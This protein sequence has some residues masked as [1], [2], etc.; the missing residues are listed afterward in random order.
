MFENFS[1]V[2]EGIVNVSDGVGRVRLGARSGLVIERAL[3][4]TI[5][6][7]SS[8][9]K[10]KEEEDD[11][12]ECMNVTIALQ[13]QVRDSSLELPETCQNLNSW[14][15]QILVSIEYQE[16]VVV[17]MHLQENRFVLSWTT[18]MK[19]N[20]IAMSVRKPFRW[21][22]RIVLRLVWVMWM[23]ILSISGCCLIILSP[24]ETDPWT[25]VRKKNLKAFDI[26]STLWSTIP[27]HSTKQA[28]AA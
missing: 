17:V 13:F 1:I 22:F 14:D 4:G 6:G 20:G 26:N 19:R 28:V 11:D 21:Y 27:T 25:T 24:I 23:I 15:L 5:A 18:H 8:A 10:S 16:N 12:E 9:V 2:T 7:C 3:Y